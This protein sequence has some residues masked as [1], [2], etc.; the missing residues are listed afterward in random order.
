MQPTLVLIVSTSAAPS[1][2][3]D[4]E[5]HSVSAQRVALQTGGRGRGTGSRIKLQCARPASQLLYTYCDLPQAPGARVLKALT[6]A[7]KGAVA[8]ICGEKVRLIYSRVCPL[9][10]CSKLRR[11]SAFF[12]HLALPYRFTLCRW[13]T[14]AA[15]SASAYSTSRYPFVRAPRVTRL[16]A[17]PY[18]M[19]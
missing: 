15:A 6:L 7:A 11:A 9:A 17:G 19:R 10:S 5:D 1:K 16:F 4:D 14:T 8:S 12:V 3:D 2:E 18:S 13:S